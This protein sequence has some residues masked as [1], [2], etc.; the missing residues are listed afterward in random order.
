MADIS[1]T[2]MTILS[3][4]G[5]SL[6]AAAAL[7]M[8]LAPDAAQARARSLRLRAMIP[9]KSKT[10]AAALVK[11]GARKDT[12]L[13]LPFVGNVGLLL[14]RADME[15]SSFGLCMGVL[16]GGAV[17]GALLTLVISPAL[18]FPAGMVLTA[19]IVLQLVK[20]RHS[21]RME[22]LT[23][24]LPDALDLMMRGLRVGHPINATITNVGRTM[25]DPVGAEFRALAHQISH[26][27]YL[28]DAFRDFADRTG[29]EDVEYLSVS[30]AIQHGTGGNLA[31]MIGTLSKVVRARIMMRRRVKAISSEGRISAYLLSALPVLIYVATSITAPAYYADVSDDPMFKPMAFAIVA[32]IVANFL[33]LRK[34][35]SFEV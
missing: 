32:L 27:D 33:A 1:L 17:F 28:T 10:E 8:I 15:G 19:I 3:V 18:A 31:N 16:G 7:R 22:A 2:T 23:L 13:S 5:C 25:A 4:I 6:L 30:I 9:Q 29:H 34:L 24:Q 35:V 12:G 26:G 14:R 11:S 21:K 20:R